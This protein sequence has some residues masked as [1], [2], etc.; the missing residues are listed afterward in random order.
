MAGHALRGMASAGLVLIVVETLA[1][2]NA[3]NG[4]GT[5]G[6]FFTEVNNLVQRAF[7]PDVPLIP[8]RRTG[9]SSGP[10]PT[11]FGVTP[12][13]AKAGAQVATNLPATTVLTDPNGLFGTGLSQYAAGGGIP[14]YRAPR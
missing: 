5:V 4:G 7:S 9:G 6:G 11:Y 10:A 12:Q 8:D 13:A 14:A 2:S 1:R 3:G